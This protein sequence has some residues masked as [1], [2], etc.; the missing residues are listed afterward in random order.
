MININCISKPAVDEV[1]SLLEKLIQYDTRTNENSPGKEVKLLLENELE[2]EFKKYG[3]DVEYFESNGHFSLLASKKG[4]EPSILYSGHVDVV[5]WDDRWETDPTTMIT[6]TEAGE[7]VVKG[8]GVSDMKSGIAALMTALPEISKTDLTMYFAITGDEE[9]GGEDGTRVIVDYLVNENQLPK[10]VI[11]ADA[12]GM[13]I[14]TRRRNVFDVFVSSQKD[15]RTIVGTTMKK[16]FYSDIISS[17]TS[18]AAY[19][20]KKFDKHAL[21]LAVDYLDD[22]GYLPVSIKGKFVKINVIPNEVEIEYIIPDD[23]GEELHYDFGL[24]ALL[25]F[26]SNIMDISF[27][28]LADSDYDINSTSNVIHNKKDK[29]ELEV[30][31]RAMLNQEADELDGQILLLRDNINWHLS[32]EV[33]KSIGFIAT[34]ND[35]PLVKSTTNILKELGY[36]GKS[37]ERGGATDGRFFAHHGIEAI[38]IGA[39]GWNVH[40]PNETATIKSIKDLVTFFER[41]ASEIKKS[42]YS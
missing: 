6:T 18:H 21:K 25:N 29:W 36:S 28:T 30:D 37:A 26:A 33:K 39:I 24:Y 17:Q 7:E 12:A 14:I 35:S 3:F 11:T 32:I 2:P 27:E 9:I 4:I 13:E 19:F 15:M 20:R 22:N 40:G 31:I 5:P 23:E 42:N 8:R 16:S 38:D 10:Y 41:S 34:P 1:I